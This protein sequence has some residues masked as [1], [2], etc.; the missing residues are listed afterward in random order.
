MNKYFN[1]FGDMLENPNGNIFA[2]FFGCL[3]FFIG[4]IIFI[5]FLIVYPIFVG[6]YCAIRGFFYEIR[7]D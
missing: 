1:F 6:I 4:L 3:G 5:P 7:H 2:P